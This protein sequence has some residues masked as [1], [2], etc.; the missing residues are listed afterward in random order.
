MFE[1]AKDQLVRLNDVELRE[2]VARLCE[3]E[4]GYRG[5]PTSAVRWDGS[6][7]APDGGLDVEVLIRDQEFTGDFVPRAWTGIQVKKS[8]TPAGE[9]A[10]E[11]RPQGDVRPVLSKLA[12]ANGCYIIVSMADDP[13]GTNLGDREN[14]MWD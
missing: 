9:I 13:A 7:T 2:L 5:A 4:L 14:A 8:S 3:A 6:Q 12:R 10:K 11:M 1:I